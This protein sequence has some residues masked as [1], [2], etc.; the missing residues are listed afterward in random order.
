MSKNPEPILGHL[1]I[2]CTS[3][4]VTRHPNVDKAASWPKCLVEVGRMGMRTSNP[5]CGAGWKDTHW[6]RNDA[7]IS[8][9]RSKM[10]A[11]MSTIMSTEEARERGMLRPPFDELA[12]HR[13]FV[14]R[15]ASVMDSV[16]PGDNLYQRILDLREEILEKLGFYP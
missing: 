13:L 14:K 1:T 6:V 4:H 10:D 5:V 7:Y 16:A 8:S 3:G 15:L 11:A 9:V 12:A 2:T